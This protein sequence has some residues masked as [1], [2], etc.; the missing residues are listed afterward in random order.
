MGL[1]Q[2]SS[3]VSLWAAIVLSSALWGCGP[4][5]R[6]EDVSER[7]PEDTSPSG[8]SSTDID[9]VDV[10]GD[11][12]LDIFVA[13]GTASIE[14]RPDRLLINDGFGTFADE[15]SA[16]LP[17][18]VTNSSRSDWGDADGDGDLDLTVGTVGPE[19]LLP[20]DG[21]GF[22]L[23]ESAARLPPPP[24][25]LEDISAEARFADVDGD[26]D[27]D[28]LIANENPFVA[29]PLAGGQNRL[30]L[31]LGG[32]FFS[33]ETAARLPLRTDQS[34]GFA[35]GDLEG[36]GDLDVIV[37]NRGPE[38]VLVNDGEGFFA[39]E[40]GARFPEVS[41]TSRGAALADLDGDTDLDLLVANSRGEAPRLYFN[42]GAGFFEEGTFTL[43]PPVYE[44][45]TAVELADVDGDGDLDALFANAGPFQEGHG[46][47]G[48]QELYFMNNGHGL[49]LDRTRA[50]FPKVLDPS[51]DV[52]WGDLDGDGDLDVAVANS[53]PGGGER[54]YLHRRR[55]H[56]ALPSGE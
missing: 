16:R 7:L 31:N 51:L 15:S 27:L 12:D 39:D 47:L 4:G 55:P 48:G 34:G 52:A 23:D 20:N 8:T 44:T 1:Q 2:L 6:L 54:L 46:F 11:G 28:I 24:A 14:G 50:H 40:T 25:L 41:D 32:G 26:G 30:Y 18:A 35:I 13:E 49:F 19:R 9:L 17:P 38:Y 3:G 37:I 43:H 29:S 56:H 5:F 22:F 42:K 45:L 33:D 21:A 10:D 36:D 53:D